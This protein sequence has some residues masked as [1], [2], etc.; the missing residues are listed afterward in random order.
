MINI[1]TNILVR[2]FV[3][4]NKEQYEQ[5]KKIFKHDCDFFI[6]SYTL[7]EFVWVLRSKKYT[8]MEIYNC[9]SELVELKH[10]V[11]GQKDLVINSLNR[12]KKGKADFA[13][14]MILEDGIRYG[15]KD[16]KTF[17]KILLNEL[18]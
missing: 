8:R 12:Y 18:K 5:A 3:N 9:L 15:S 16:F 14:Y 4:D 17:D 6:S 1:D 7:L 13:D 11:I 10:I 2:V